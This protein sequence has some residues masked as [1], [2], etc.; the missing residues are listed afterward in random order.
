MSGGQGGHGV[1]HPLCENIDFLL[2]AQ[3][4]YS[5]TKKPKT[6]SDLYIYKIIYMLTQ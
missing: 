5:S 3:I 6:H 2:H 1:P 4:S